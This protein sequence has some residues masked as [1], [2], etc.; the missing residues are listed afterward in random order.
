MINLYYVRYGKDYVS[1]Y[2][3]LEDAFATANHHFYEGYSCCQT[4]IDESEHKI[5][6]LNGDIEVD[7]EFYNYQHNIYDVINTNYF[8]DDSTWIL[9]GT[10]RVGE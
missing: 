5:Y 3:T 9:S 4:V 7:D 6:T 2:D 10:H 8:D 1:S